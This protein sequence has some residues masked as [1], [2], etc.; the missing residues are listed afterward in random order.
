[1]PDDEFSASLAS[2]AR[3]WVA[4]NSAARTAEQIDG[5]TRQEPN[6]IDP[7]WSP[8]QIAARPNF[9]ARTVGTNERI[10]EMNQNK[11]LDQPLA[12]P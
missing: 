5:E 3:I 4:A 12:S 2:I 7:G 1:V 11:P 9:V 8:Y 10:L 6:E